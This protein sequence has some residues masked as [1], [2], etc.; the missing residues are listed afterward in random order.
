M[1]RG[2]TDPVS[3]MRVD[4]SKALAAEHA[5]RTNLFCSEHCRPPFEANP[6]AM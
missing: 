5:G 4:R 6:D 3:G 1:R 2:A